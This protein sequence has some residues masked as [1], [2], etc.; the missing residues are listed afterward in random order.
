MDDDRFRPLL[1]D[2]ASLLHAFEVVADPTKVERLRKLMQE[3]A[4][5]GVSGP[6]A[7]LR[8]NAGMGFPPGQS[9]G[10]GLVMW[11]VA[12]KQPMEAAGWTIESLAEL[13]G[14]ISSLPEH[15]EDPEEGG[16]DNG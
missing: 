3:A 1:V 9:L 10:L 12:E 13:L 11:W 7:V 5:A 15:T 16:D 6:E 2:Q 8:V 14:D 4:E